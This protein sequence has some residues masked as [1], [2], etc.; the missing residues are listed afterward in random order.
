MAEPAIANKFLFW[1]FH[2]GCPMSVPDTSRGFFFFVAFNRLLFGPN[3][4]G[5]RKRRGR[6]VL[7]MSRDGVCAEAT[8]PGVG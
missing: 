8:R 5:K 2:A 4:F 3:M 1:Q 6:Q 7:R